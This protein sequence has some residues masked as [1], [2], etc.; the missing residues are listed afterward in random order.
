MTDPEKNAL[1]TVLSVAL[2]ATLFVDDKLWA[3]L[4][5]HG[6]QQSLEHGTSAAAPVFYASFAIVSGA[7]FGRYQDGY[8]FGKLALA[9]LQD[10][11]RL[12]VR[13][14]VSMIFGYLLSYWVEPIEAGIPHLERSV[15]E[16]VESGNIT[17]ACYSAA[18]FAAVKLTQGLPLAEVER[19][20]SSS[21][22][23]RQAHAIRPARGQHP[24]HA[25]L[26]S[27]HARQ[28]RPR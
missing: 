16:G 2:P 21:P 8:R 11:N 14:S 25:A 7:F 23:L 18:C 6:V 27:A 1:M 24:H 10:R 15:R 5:C 28:R 12:A 13:S 4:I 9:L 19:E 22:G 20:A 26:R 17:Y 3:L